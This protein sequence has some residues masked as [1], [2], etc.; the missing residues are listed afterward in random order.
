M[1]VDLNLKQRFQEHKYSFIH[2]KLAISTFANHILEKHHP[3][4]PDSFNTIKIIN[5]K[6]LMIY[7]RI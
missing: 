7:G 6:K 2:N 4:I 1:N 3:L 5:D